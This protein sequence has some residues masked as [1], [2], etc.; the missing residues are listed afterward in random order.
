MLLCAMAPLCVAH[1]QPAE[2]EIQDSASARRMAQAVRAALIPPVNGGVWRGLATAWRTGD[3]LRFVSVGARSVDGAAIDA[4]TLFDIGEV[5]H[6]L[7]ATLVAVLVVRDEL[8]L[9]RP[10]QALLPST[11][12]VPRF[13]GRS[14]TVGDLLF[15]RSGLPGV[16]IADGDPEGFGPRVRT[17]LA[18]VRLDRDVGSA[19]EYSPLGLDLL[20]VALATHLGQSVDAA[21][22]Q[23][24]LAPLEI[25]DIQPS[26][27]ITDTLRRA[28][29]YDAAGQPVA[30]RIGAHWLGSARG[31][32]R[33]ALAASDTTRG[34]LAR[35]FALMLRARSAGPDSTLPQALGWRVIQ[36]DERE[37][38][39]FDAQQAPGY[40]SFVTID[41]TRQAVAVVLT[42]S[43]RPVDRIAGQLVRGRVP[44]LGSTPP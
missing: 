40:S 29:G 35:A 30:A 44:V 7:T 38:Y 13:N 22:R 4:G 33:F 26:W 25:R 9:D 3:S 31:L 12:R 2:R 39:W 19:Y 28:T 16:S 37:V 6:L 36:I 34:P 18:R 17:A 24:V 1:A 32:S 41:P 8:S 10:V 27:A 5:G 20:T 43:A 21:V 11:Y 15:H 23:R 14:I 42:N